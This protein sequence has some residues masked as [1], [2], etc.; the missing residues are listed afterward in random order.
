MSLR[1]SC[2]GNRPVG[3]MKVIWQT[4][5]GKETA[6]EL[7]FIDELL[8]RHIPHENFFDRSTLGAIEDGALVIYSCDERSVDE[9][10]LRY[11]AGGKNFNLLHLSNERL[12]HRA[13]YYSLANTVL[14][15]Y[16][17]PSLSFSN[18]YS[19]P[20]GFKSGFSNGK[21]RADMARVRTYIWSFAGQLKNDR[22]RMVET[23]GK[24]GSHFVLTTISWDAE[25]GLSVPKLREIYEQ[26]IFVP[27]PFGNINPDSFRVMESLECGCIPVCLEFGGIDYFKYIYGDHPFL[28]CR[29]WKH[30]GVE[31][32]A[33]LADPIALR[34]RQMRVWN[35]YELFKRNLVADI[36]RLLAGGKGGALLSEQFLYQSQGKRDMGLKVGFWIR[37]TLKRFLVSMFRA[38]VP[39]R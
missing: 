20:P 33:L 4:K 36:E 35:W 25:D 27:C 18:T 14:R 6:F 38:A 13:H 5:S 24:L 1:K 39:G 15:S 28:I 32:K 37:V 23:L 7:Q 12:G 31:I 8:L 21:N 22:V 34:D 30:A 19:I 11:L 26:T 17:D 9:N 16:F 29:S 10:F 3:V 2:E